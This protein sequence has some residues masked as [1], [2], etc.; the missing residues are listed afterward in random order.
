MR[1]LA[2]VCAMLGSAGTAAAQDFRP[3]SVQESSRGVRI[4]LMGFGVRTGFSVTSPRQIVF[5]TT[6]DLG[7]LYSSRVRPR[8][9]LEVGVGGGANSYVTSL[10]SIFRFTEDGDVAVPY[11]GLGMSIAGHEGC[12]PDPDCPD[13]WANVVLG[14]E[15]RYRATFNW[16]VE[17]HGMDAFRR[18]RLY[19]GLTTR[20]S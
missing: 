11:F 4:G 20:R 13:L 18:H 1:R 2:L 9:S 17:Y 7:D 5:G 10:E 19:L 8:A 3:P 16:L 6:L 14:F 15:L 12:G